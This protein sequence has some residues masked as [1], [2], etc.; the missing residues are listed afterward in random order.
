VLLGLGDIAAAEADAR[1][2]ITN[3]EPHNPLA[4]AQIGPRV[5]LA[6][7]RLAEGDPHTAVGLLAPIASAPGAVALLDGRR[8]ALA[9][10]ADAL[11]ADGRGVEARTWIERALEAPTEGV[12][13]RAY[14]VAVLNRVRAVA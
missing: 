1:R 13:A 3:V 6:L 4:P 8:P 14:A 12:R 7:C 5:L 11:L 10:Y 9:A 2:V